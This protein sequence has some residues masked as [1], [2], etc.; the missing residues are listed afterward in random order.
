MTKKDP[1]EGKDPKSIKDNII[2]CKIDMKRVHNEPL[3]ENLINIC[4]TTDE[5]QRPH[6]FE[7]LNYLN[8]LE[9]EVYGDISSDERK[10]QTLQLQPSS[11]I[12]QSP[13]TSGSFSQSFDNSF[14]SESSFRESQSKGQNKFSSKNQWKKNK[15]FNSKKGVKLN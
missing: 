5:N 3:L 10:D 1:F 15:F 2:K 8:K 13:N 6:A 7:L 4:L 14:N 9:K 11:F 12:T